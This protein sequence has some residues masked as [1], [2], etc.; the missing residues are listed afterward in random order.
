MIDRGNFIRSDADYQALFQTYFAL[1]RSYPMR[2]GICDYG[3]YVFE[4]M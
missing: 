3:I 2:S 4:R 1:K